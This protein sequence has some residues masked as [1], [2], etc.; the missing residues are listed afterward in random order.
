MQETH[1]DLYDDPEFEAT[2]EDYDL[3]SPETR[4]S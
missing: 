1:P 3:D 2:S 4:S